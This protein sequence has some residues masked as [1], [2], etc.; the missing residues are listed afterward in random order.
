MR[1]FKI[2]I[3]L[4]LVFF[5]FLGLAIQCRI[6][7]K[8]AEGDTRGG[9]YRRVQF[10]SDGESQAIKPKKK[11]DKGKK[12]LEM[13]KSKKVRLEKVGLSKDQWAELEKEYRSIYTPE[14]EAKIKS[15][16]DKKAIN[17]IKKPLNNEFTDRMKDILTPEQYE[18][19]KSAKNK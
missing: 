14:V 15:M 1:S 5:F 2:I 8:R 10:E 16:S 18:E 17:E 13:V 11:K 12:S 4:F 9:S 19:Y 3:I 6:P 7:D